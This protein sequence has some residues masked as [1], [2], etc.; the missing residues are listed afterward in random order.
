MT[1]S[2]AVAATAVVGGCGDGSAG[3]VVIEPQPSANDPGPPL[4]QSE[5]GHWEKLIGTSFIISNEASRI[6]ATLSTV[7]RAEPDSKRPADVARREPFYAY[8]EMDPKL[9][10]QGGKTYQLSHATKGVF[11]LFL[12]QP[13]EIFGKG[14]MLA[15][16]N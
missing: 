8:F 3:S 13:S 6:P 1:G 16:L 10:P 14:V 9:V 2:L 7:T 15:V 11:D 5:A 12:G 4:I